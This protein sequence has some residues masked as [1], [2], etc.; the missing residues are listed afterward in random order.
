MSWVINNPIA[1]IAG[2]LLSAAV[3]WLGTDFAKAAQEADRK[4]NFRLQ[5]YLSSYAAVCL[6]LGS[7]GCILFAIRFV[8]WVWYL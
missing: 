5:A 2:F 8:R 1:I 4:E 7:F 3:L 6:P